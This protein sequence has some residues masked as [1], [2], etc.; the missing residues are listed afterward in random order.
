MVRLAAG[1]ASSMQHKVVT[2][3]NMEIER[4]PFGFEEVLL[5]STFAQRSMG[6]MITVGRLHLNYL[7]TLTQVFAFLKN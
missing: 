6:T 5:D 4:Q 3:S 1:G 7:Y 2:Y